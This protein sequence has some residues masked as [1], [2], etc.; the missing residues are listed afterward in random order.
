MFYFSSRKEIVD[1]FN[2]AVSEILCTASTEITI[3]IP[4]I[5]LNHSEIIASKEFHFIVQVNNKNKNP[6]HASSNMLY[7]EL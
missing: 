2:C 5:I 3:P 6:A 1:V 4:A 7:A